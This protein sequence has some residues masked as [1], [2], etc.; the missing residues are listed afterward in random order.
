M[1]RVK[2]TKFV[3]WWPESTSAVWS[4]Q[5]L[6]ANLAAVFRR[7]QMEAFRAGMAGVPMYSPVFAPLDDVVAFV[8]GETDDDKISDL[9]WG[10]LCIEYPDSHELP[11][12]SQGNMPFEFGVI[13]LLVEEKCFVAKGAYWNLDL[14]QSDGNAKPDPDVFHL[15]ASGQKNA[16][17]LS[18]DRAASRLKAGGLLVTGHCNR[19]R[20]GKP[21]SVLSH[22][23]PLRLL[24][25]MMFPLSH[26]DLERIA[27]KFLYP[28]ESE[29]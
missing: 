25:S 16:V 18:V 29:E 9:L 20:S 10:L 1:E 27:N 15:L 2:V 26:R 4:E 7:R 12:P 19:R 8:K 11:L 17:G 14:S 21:L 13:R 6:A 22:V 24:A 3:K 5:P 28:T 23:A